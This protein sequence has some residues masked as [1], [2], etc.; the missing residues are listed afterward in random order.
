M[1]LTQREIADV[2]KISESQF[3]LVLSGNRHLEYLAAVQLSNL[4]PS[5]PIIWIKGGGTSEQR[6][7]AYF[8]H[9]MKGV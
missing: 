1:K 3:S 6:R 5:S 4:I 7:R 8:E 2:L 9:S